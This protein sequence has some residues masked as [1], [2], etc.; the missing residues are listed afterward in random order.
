MEGVNRMRPHLKGV[1]FVWQRREEEIEA[2]DC[3]FDLP[4]LLQLDGGQLSEAVCVLETA[5]A[6]VSLGA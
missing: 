2:Q 1:D 5:T 3:A 4:V 6:N